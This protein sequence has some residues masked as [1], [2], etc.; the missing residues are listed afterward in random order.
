MVQRVKFSCI[1]EF[2]DDMHG[3]DIL[4]L[5][6]QFGDSIDAARDATASIVQDRPALDMVLNDVKRVLVD[7]GF[8]DTGAV[9]NVNGEEVWHFLRGRELV[10][11]ISN[12]EIDEELL[13]ALAGGD[14]NE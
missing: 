9:P 14:E 10:D 11:V 1:L 13:E 5:A 8:E 2:P 7:A 6:R 12:P 3:E 4:S